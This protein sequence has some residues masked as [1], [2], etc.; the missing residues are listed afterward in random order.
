M[1][2]VLTSAQEDAAAILEIKEDIRD[3][4]S[5]LGAVTNVVLFDK[6]AEGVASVRFGDELAARECV[7]VRLKYHSSPLCL[8]TTIPKVMHG[9][10]FGGQQLIAHIAD[11][12]EKF[13]KSNEK[14]EPTTIDED[15]LD[16]ATSG[17][18]KRLD[19]F[20]AWLEGDQAGEG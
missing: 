20:G 3:E 15:E 8:L 1:S 13:Q 5:K 10:F 14:A 4:C 9:R 12:H 7:R 2:P 17:E 19:E 6:E 11:G 16:E 18:S